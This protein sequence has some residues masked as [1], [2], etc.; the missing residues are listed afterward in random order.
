MTS[1][2][3]GAVG[4]AVLA[5]IDPA[6]T[7]SRATRPLVSMVTSSPE[8]VERADAV[9]RQL[10]RRFTVVRGQIDGAAGTILVG[11]ALPDESRWFPSPVV[12]VTPTLPATRIRVVAFEVP[13]TSPL[14]ARIPVDVRVRVHAALG[15]TLRLELRGNGATVES[16]TMPVTSA[17]DH[18][19]MTF[20]YVP[21]AP[22]PVHLTTIAM[23]E[24]TGDADSSSVLT[25]VR[26]DRFS[27]LF[28]D[29]RAS[30]PSTFVRRAVESDPRFV[31][32]SRVL[33]SRGVSNASGTAPASLRDAAALATFSTIVV[34]SPDQ[35]S[36]GDVRALDAFMRTRG[37]RVVLLLDGGT[38]GSLN[39]LT[40]V[41]RW[42]SARL[43]APASLADSGDDGA[44]RA[45]TLVWPSQRPIG[46][47]VLATN[48]ADDSSRRSVVWSVPVGAG[49]L[50]VSGAV[51]AWHQRDP[52]ASG[53]DAFWTNTL[54]RLSAA[55]PPRVDVSLSS[56]VL[57]PA[58]PTEI[59]VTVREVALAE[60][61]TQPVDATA[62]LI[63]GAESTLV[64][65]WPA[66]VTGTFVGTFVAPREPALHHLNVVAS[67]TRVSVPFVVETWARPANDDD[68]TLVGAFVSSRGGFVVPESN[69][70]DLAGRLT[71]AFQP[72]SRVETWY[73]MRSGWWIV[74]FALLLG[75]EW[76]W[77]RRRGLA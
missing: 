45:Q 26:D 29:H 43:A 56:R 54:A 27:V 16:R 38:G 57:A 32:T 13:A 40:G 34:G 50:L 33:T 3:L 44:L 53:F 46:A 60:R 23:L 9:T 52:A 49:Q 4:I 69:P 6:L 64:R 18:M 37:G 30:W 42:R 14:N 61:P 7:S 71:A 51:D 15:R 59:R 68:S 28:F 66:V 48:V 67:G 17:N 58:Q 76:W 75:A 39:R 22:G 65:L 19:A 72:V 77:R 35:V 36:D 55:A 74:P 12:A 47:T 41:E 31:V 20:S 24:G 11:D 63:V 70:G 62:T 25:E 21:V 5:V 73:P 2:R 1:W 8:H 10:G